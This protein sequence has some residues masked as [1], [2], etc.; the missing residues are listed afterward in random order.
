MVNNINYSEKELIE[1]AHKRKELIENIVETQKS[2]EKF[3]DLSN[4]LV[5][6]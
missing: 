3:S 5:I 6:F 4:F 2:I 1:L